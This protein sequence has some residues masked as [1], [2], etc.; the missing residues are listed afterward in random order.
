MN[1]VII[2]RLIVLICL[3]VSCVEG[4][5]STNSLLSRSSKNKEQDTKRVAETNWASIEE[6]Q[7]KYITEF[8]SGGSGI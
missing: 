5:Q 8:K 7:R 6:S 3:Q 2:T 1:N 4:G